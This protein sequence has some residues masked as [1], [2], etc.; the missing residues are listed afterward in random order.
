MWNTVSATVDSLAQEAS[1]CTGQ[2]DGHGPLAHSMRNSIDSAYVLTI[3]S[4]PP[5]ETLPPS[6]PAAAIQTAIS[7]LPISPLRPRNMA[8]IP[9]MT[10]TT[11]L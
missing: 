1:V 7:H 10:N 6:T 11:K 8:K 2:M 9:S 3:F 4:L 5:V